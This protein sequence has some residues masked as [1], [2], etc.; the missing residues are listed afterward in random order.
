MPALQLHTSTA[1]LPLTSRQP[2]RLTGAA[3]SRLRAVT[4]VLWVTIDQDP[5]DHVLLAGDSLEVESSRDVL[6]TA[7]GRRATLAVCA[8]A[9]PATAAT[10]T[11]RQALAW[12]GWPAVPAPVTLAAW[13]QAAPG[14]QAC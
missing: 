13:A 3:G 6:V 10:T 4:G 11:W 2:L 7:L 12:V 8:P 9:T 1:H 14:R 5:V